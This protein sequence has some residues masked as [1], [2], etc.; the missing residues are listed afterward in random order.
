MEWLAADVPT[1]AREVYVERRV[2]SRQNRAGERLAGERGLNAVD[3]GSRPG[4]AHHLF[5]GAAAE[6]AEK[7]HERGLHTR[8][9]AVTPPASTG[10]REFDWVNPEPLHE[11]IDLSPVAQLGTGEQH[12]GR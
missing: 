4:V 1:Y 7:D 11:D 12:R 6:I 5:D 9:H 8:G 3:S 10:D 2:V